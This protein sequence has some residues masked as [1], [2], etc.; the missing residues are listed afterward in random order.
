MIYI[1]TVSNSTTTRTRSEHVDNIVL[2]ILLPDRKLAPPFS[3]WS[4]A[5][6]RLLARSKRH[7]LLLPEDDW[8]DHLMIRPGNIPPPLPQLLVYTDALPTSAADACAP[9]P[10]FSA[11]SS[12]TT[13]GQYWGHA[14]GRNRNHS[15]SPASPRPGPLQQR[16]P[17]DRRPLCSLLTTVE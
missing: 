8:H 16:P 14:G 13:V 7:L 9:V 10:A 3:M 15:H 2:S 12:P 17:R 6:P 1:M 5:G 4:A 11:H